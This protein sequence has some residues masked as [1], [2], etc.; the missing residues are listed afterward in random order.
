MEIISHLEAARDF[1]QSLKGQSVYHGT[2]AA[3]GE[4]IRNSLEAADIDI[5]HA[6]RIAG[7]IKS[8]GWDDA[9]VENMIMLLGTAGTKKLEAAVGKRNGLQDFRWITGYFTRHEWGDVFL[10]GDAPSTVKL[11]LVAARACQLKLRN[12]SEPTFQTL[13]AL[14]LASSEGLD[15]AL[16]QD[17]LMK[18]HGFRHVKKIMKARR[19]D[20]QGVMVLPQFERNKDGKLL[21]A[22]FGT[23]PCITCQFDV[24]KFGALVDSIPMRS[25]SGRVRNEYTPLTGAAD[26]AAKFGA[27]LEGLVRRFAVE[28]D[29]PKRKTGINLTMCA[30]PKRRALCGYAPPPAGRSPSTKETMACHHIADA[31]AETGDG[32][33][34][35]DEELPLNMSMVVA[36]SKV[37]QP[38]PAVASVAESAAKIM[39]AMMGGDKTAAKGGTKTKSKDKKEEEDAPDTQKKKA[40][41]KTASAHYKM[42][43]KAMVCFDKGGNKKKTISFASAGGQ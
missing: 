32:S 15:A 24:A 8:I 23:E 6:G 37:D 39:A 10:S 16:N 22:I 42:V 41:K 35:D 40:K 1:L 19:S 29:G 17:G 25:T 26:P 3:Q 38:K 43:G 27:M 36:P 5:M 14:W 7:L 9:L 21:A 18:H 33:D 34:A 2:L 11:D 4:A 28:D 20:V 13:T 31:N 12:G 30:P